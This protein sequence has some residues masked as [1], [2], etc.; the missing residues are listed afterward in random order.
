MLLVP[1]ACFGVLESGLRLAGYGYPTSFLL[2]FSHEGRKLFIQNIHFGWRFFGPQM[3]RDPAAFAIPQTRET[4]TVRIFVFGESAAYGD[5]QPEFGLPRMLQAIL[6][7]RHPGVKFEVVNAAMTGINSHVIL[8]IARDCARADGDIWV[9]YMGNN[10]V[11]GPFGAGTVFGPHTPPLPL[12]R[13]SVAFKATRTGELFDSLFRRF[14]QPPAD[15]SEWGGMEMFLDQQVRA[16]DPRMGRVYRHFSQNLSDILQAGHDC[17]AGIVVST[18]AVNLKDC[19]PF[20]SQ[21]RTGLSDTD[22]ARWDELFQAGVAAQQAG[23]VP[24]AATQFQAAAQ[25][26]DSYAEL[27]FRQG[28]CALALG[29]AAGAQKQFAAA[30]D[31]DT[32][33]FRCDT[34][35]N[36]LIRQIA[37]H[38][39]PE[40]ILLA[41]SDRAFAD[42]S[43]DGLPGEDLFYEHVHLTFEGNYLLARTLD[44]QLEQLL[45]GQIATSAKPMPAIADCASRLAWTAWNRES[46]LADVIARLNSPPF[47]GQSTHDSQVARYRSLLSGLS[48]EAQPATA[49]QAT[50]AAVNA[51]PDD[52]VLRAQLATLKA[53]S[54]DVSG[55]E[56]DARRAVELLPGCPEDWSL[57]GGVL[58]TQGKF[59]DATR[60]YRRAVELSPQD[61]FDLQHLAQALTKLGRRDEAIG[62]YERAVA[63]KPRF[64]PGWLGLGLLREQAG[65]QTE[66]EKCFQKALAN[67]VRLEPEL[68][69]LARFCRDRKQIDDAV[70]FYA[71]AIQLSPLNVPLRI[72]LGQC[73]S[74]AGRHEQ[75]V[76]CF[77]DLAQLAPDLMEAHLLLGAELLHSGREA[78]AEAQFREVV[79][80]SPD[81]IK[82]QLNLGLTLV[83][84]KRYS[85]ALV[86]FDQVLRLSPQNELALQYDQALRKK[87]A[88]AGSP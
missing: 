36:E 35:L 79:R 70:K 31:L 52:P 59:E 10:E 51:A 46:V 23:K 49:Y 50:A 26:D 61:V 9:I 18:V 25:T 30:R 87:L 57:L 32:L 45:P 41:D 75:A 85:E 4:G 8:P 2:P 80:L 81:S 84:Q 42:Q 22:K 21:H 65:D 76:E 77:A 12:I 67:P 69:E 63:I 66:A 56:P 16:D 64:G 15:K 83:G 24:A 53:Y 62:A 71:Q 54:G 27:R 74:A 19:A 3:A 17:G 39:E 29:D 34:R 7:L 13:A 60:A 28:Q 72:E 82:E 38:R 58:A 44:G 33:R 37:G 68:L 14:N 40:R 20:S 1:L 5:P 86:E 47:T 43:P 73:L 48:A 11:V 6:E 88:G 78:E 55:A